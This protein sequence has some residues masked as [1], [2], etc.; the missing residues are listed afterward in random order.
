VGK[1]IKTKQKKWW[2]AIFTNGI[3]DEI[4]FI[5]KCRR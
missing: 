4:Y 5:G 3:T 1:K 2:L